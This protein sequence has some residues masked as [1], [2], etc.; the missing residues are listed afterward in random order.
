MA[1]R[2]PLK[3]SSEKIYDVITNFNKGIDKKTADDVSLD[4]SFEN[5]TNFYN[6]AEGYLSKRPGVYNS[7]IKAFINDLA[8]EN[9]DSTKFVISANKFGETKA[10]LI[11]RLKDFNNTIFLGKK[12]TGA[13]Y[14]DTTFT[15][16]ADKVVG[17][18]LLKNAF[19]FEAI[20]DKENLFQGLPCKQVNGDIIEFSFIML[21]GGFYTSIKNSVESKKKHGLYVCRFSIKM[22]FKDTY[23]DVQIEFDSV[24]STMNP[25][26]NGSTYACRWDYSPENH[27]VGDDS[28][29]PGYTLDIS[30]FN[31]YSYVATGSNYLLKI[32]QFPDIKTASSKYTGE[33]DIIMQLGG[34]AGENLYSPTAI[35][36]NQVG[37]NIL[38]SDP[39]KHYTIT[40]ATGKTKGIFFTKKVTHNGE[41]FNQ[42][43]AKIP[44]N[45]TFFIHVLYAGSEAPKIQYRE[46][47]GETDIEKNAYKDMPGAWLTNSNKTIWECTGI[48][49]DSRLEL[50]LTLGD[51]EFRSYVETTTTPES[52]VGYINEISDLIF[53][54]KH[55]KVINNQ[56]VLYGGHGYVFFSEYDVFNY[57]PNYYYIYV[58]SEAGEESVTGINYFRQYYAI[59]T[60]K[61]IKRM[62]GS[63][64]TDTFGVYPLS[65]FIGCPN[66]RTIRPVGNNLLFLG[67][68][69]IYRL[70]QGYLGEGTENIEKIDEVLGGDL[71]LNNV[72]Q[73]LVINNNYIIVKNDGKTWVVY[74]TTTDAFYEY[75]LESLEGEVYKGTQ[76]DEELSNATLNFY[77]IFQANLYDSYGDFLVVPMYEYGFSEDYEST[78]KKGMNL[79]L[80]RF[81][82][83]NFLEMEERHKDGYGFISNLETHYMN[84][85]YPTHNKKFKNLFIKMIN[86]S[87]HP[88]PLY[89]TI[90]VD[91]KVVMTPSNYEVVY[92][93]EDDTYYYVEKIKE[94]S[95]LTVGRALGEFVLNEDTMGNKTIQQL[96]IRIGE[97]GKA[98]KI[99]LSDGFNDYTDLLIPDEKKGFAIRNRNPYDFSISTIGIVY[100][101]KKVKEG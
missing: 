79:M 17:F 62:E 72:I 80:F 52:N 30:N 10:S 23:Y 101:L 34:Y 31:G 6:A 89:V 100:K 45:G 75:N 46:D 32:D 85:G 64:G 81:N 97:K 93:E 35:E 29:D 24:D 38:Y 56:L 13:A 70:K 78:Y 26:K 71:N 48:N 84:M 77:S 73:A 16:E 25:Y 59:F 67:N 86:N 88:I 90:I 11:E 3:G 44:Y 53:S 18:Q 43:I 2:Q 76:V 54:S 74:N 22:E 15:Y 14:G 41:N 94:N 50:Y 99:I 1:T 37:F 21:V 91:D 65:D 82:D 87:G 5:L 51:D 58:A 83:L 60:N 7:N 39:L 12:K 27:M 69:G 19:F 28:L 63:F 68:D 57:F 4:S 95:E 61:R 55:S 9:F 20:K 92:N 40:G 47:N 66:G 49:S 96:K 98:I 42:P 36:L 8:E 33:S